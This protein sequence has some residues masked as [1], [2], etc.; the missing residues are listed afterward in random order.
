MQIT[1]VRV[2][3]IE[4]QGRQVEG[5]YCSV[6]MDNEFVVRDIK[7][8]EGNQRYFVAMLQGKMSDHAR[9][10]AGRTIFRANSALTAARGFL[11]TGQGRTVKA[12]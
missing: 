12:G 7:I 5:R 8:I 6:T 11:M 3:L 9:S 4:N 10:A 1:E 2:K